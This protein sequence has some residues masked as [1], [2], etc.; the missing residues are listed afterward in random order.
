MGNGLILINTVISVVTLALVL[1]LL[2][3]QLKKPGTK[4]ISEEVPA[5]DFSEELMPSFSFYN[6]KVHNNGL[7]SMK[8][9]NS[10]GKIK[11]IIFTPGVENI[12]FRCGTDTLDTGQETT[13]SVVPL[14]FNF[15]ENYFESNELPFTVKYKSLL[16]DYVDERYNIEN[17]ATITKSA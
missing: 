4:K 16:N 6:G 11:E 2:Y 1:V 12:E 9:K 7:V 8:L 3:L 14:G 10:G 13:I 5:K 15:T 17:P